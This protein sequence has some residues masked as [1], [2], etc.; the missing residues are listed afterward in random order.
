[1]RLEQAINFDD[2]RRMAKRHLPK[3]AFDFIE[4][5]VEDEGGLVRN[6]TAFERRCLV[7]RYFVDASKPEMATTL[8]GKTYSQPFGIAP[9]GAISTFRRGG[10]L[11]L[12]RAAHSAELPFVI[13]GASTATMEDIAA[14]APG[15]AWLQI[16][17]AKDR[18]IADDMMTRA[19]ATGISTIVITVDTPG[20]NKR[21]RNLRNGFQAIR[22]L[23][24][25]W[26]VRFEALRHPRWLYEYATGP[27]LTASNWEKYAKAAGMAN[28]L[29]FVSSQLPTPVSWAD[30][31]H[32]R[33]IWNGTLV[34]KGVMHPDDA[35]AAAERGVD[36]VIVSNHG[37]RQLDRSPAPFDVLPHI[38]EA[39]GDKATVMFDS[40]IRRGADI[41][42]A[43]A[44]GAKFCFVGR[45]TLYG[46]AAAAEP[47]AHHAV[48]MIRDEIT[49]TMT[50]I[51]A[52]SVAAL[53]RTW[54]HEDMK[55]ASG[56]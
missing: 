56:P 34:V 11:M 40:G 37:G 52:P 15:H 19:K 18:R 43:L 6:V 46:V 45:W 14:A 16:Y 36:G 9:T 4:G 1:M 39:V 26:K 44:A 49:K 20:P 8:F 31:E 2:L 29:D 48:N 17:V 38:A 53:D 41:V 47:G 3:V 5:G 27:G 42:A 33:K 50:Q 32:F 22:T 12:A 25:T 24:P 35:R 51:G 21:E 28:A 55:A 54:L 13:S 30:I 10:D 7:P 23:R